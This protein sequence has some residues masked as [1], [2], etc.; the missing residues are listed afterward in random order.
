MEM[1][2]KGSGMYDIRTLYV[3][4]YRTI[5]ISVHHRGSDVI[6]R[7]ATPQCRMPPCRLPFGNKSS[8]KVNP[9]QS[10]RGCSTMMIYV[11]PYVF[12]KF[13]L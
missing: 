9:F 1:Y 7:I 3:S 11:V 13:L 6:S 8:G 5:I 2:N 12:G 10:L 4:W